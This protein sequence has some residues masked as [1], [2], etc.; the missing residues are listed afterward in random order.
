M[1][2]IVAVSALAAVLSSGLV[3]VPAHAVPAV[4]W[5]TPTLDWQLI[6]NPETVA[7]DV[8]TRPKARITYQ[9]SSTG[10][11]STDCVTWHVDGSSSPAF[12]TTLSNIV[13][14]RTSNNVAFAAGTYSTNIVYDW[15]E[16]TDMLAL[17]PSTTHDIEVKVHDVACADISSESTT[18]SATL[19]LTSAPSATPQGWDWAATLGLTEDAANA[20]EQPD[21]GGTPNDDDWIYPGEDATFDHTSG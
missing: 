3:S 19:Q 16:I 10:D 13:E 11:S 4:S 21:L 12:T 5:S 8:Y 1:K 2:R 15:T 7:T 20:T 18:G 6:D 17:D 14:T 9:W